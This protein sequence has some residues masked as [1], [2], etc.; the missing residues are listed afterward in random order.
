MPKL[1]AIALESSKCMAFSNTA[2]QQFGSI[3]K[4]FAQNQEGLGK[5]ADDLQKLREKDLGDLEYQNKNC[6][7]QIHGMLGTLT[8]HGA[9]LH[10][11]RVS[12]E[13]LEGRLEKTNKFQAHLQPVLTHV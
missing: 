2:K 9:K 11:D 7:A 3:E 13:E 1:E 4:Q 6:M 8:A 10:K 12:L 5:L